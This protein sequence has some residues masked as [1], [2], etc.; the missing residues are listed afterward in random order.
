MEYKIDLFVKI[1][2]EYGPSTI[3]VKNSISD[4]LLSL[5]TTLQIA[6][7]YRLPKKAKKLTYSL[8]KLLFKIDN[9]S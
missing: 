7:H 2:H 5:N 4:V 8:I 6:S 9:F 1:V 3:F